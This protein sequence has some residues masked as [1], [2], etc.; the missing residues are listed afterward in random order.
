VVDQN[1]KP[2]RNF[3]VLVAFPREHRPGDKTGGFFA[4]YSGIG[5][6]FTTDDGTFAVTGVGAGCIHRVIALA[7][8]HGQAVLDRVEAIPANRMQGMAP[9]ILQASAPV[10]FRINVLNT[11]RK[12]IAGARVT[13]VNGQPGLDQNFMWGYHDASWEDMARGRSDAEGWVNFPALAYDQATVLIQAPGYA[14]YRIGW[15]EHQKEMT[16]ELAPEAILTGVVL[17]RQGKPLR[18]YYVNVTFGG[19]Q[20][21]GSV[22]PNDKGRFRIPALP[23]GDWQLKVRSDDG[24]TTLH[25]ETITLKQGETKDLKI[26]TSR[27]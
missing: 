11:A 10:P 21:A 9:A 8:G 14:R 7:E 27:E 17:G 16:V 13:L 15:R 2:I 4:G 25:E 1:G 6:R 22:G 12:P 20:I 19:D 24:R 3:R 26:E 18:E 23:A 5:V